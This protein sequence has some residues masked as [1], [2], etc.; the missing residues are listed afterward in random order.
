MGSV[1]MDVED[2]FDMVVR[3]L[4]QGQSEATPF[5]DRVLNWFRENHGDMITAGRTATDAGGAAALR[6]H[7]HPADPG[8]RV[9]VSSG[10]AVTVRADVFPVGPGFH[11]FLASALR[12]MGRALDIR[13]EVEPRAGPSAASEH[14][15]ER[16]LVEARRVVDQIGATA[17]PHLFMLPRH[18]RYEHTE[19]V[20]T[21]LGPRDMRWLAAAAVGALQLRD[22]FPWPEPGQGPRYLLGR[23]LTVM[24]TQVRWR[25]PADDVERARLVEVNRLLAAA[26][27]G[28]P[29]LDLPWAEWA[30]IRNLIDVTDDL[31]EEISARGEGVVRWPPIGY[32][33]RAVQARLPAGWWVRVPGAMGTRWDDKA[34]WCVD[35]GV[36]TARFTVVDRRERVS[37]PLPTQTMHADQLVH[38]G[39]EWRGAAR[40]T[41]PDD[42]EVRVLEGRM[43]GPES[44][45]RVTAQ[46]SHPFDRRWAET[47]F[48]S[49]EWVNP[50]EKE[51]D[52]TAELTAELAVEK[53]PQE[54]GRPPPV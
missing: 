8:V 32:R 6:V 34:T 15:Q 10:L 50:A 39:G 33:R 17:G 43:V 48:R 27:H 1:Q 52:W 23:A 11:E 40:I 51:E 4:A 36:R 2:R 37:L 28:E 24:W 12:R 9:H 42:G 16:L 45:V 13:W 25:R 54:P 38:D 44:E 22:V 49:L 26:Y 21:P 7:L 30:E 19:L 3:G 18:E 46:Y 31:T 14:A 35:D 41:R 20:A 53:P 5:A 47:L 29:N